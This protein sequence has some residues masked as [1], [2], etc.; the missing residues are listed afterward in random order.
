MPR[1]VRFPLF[2]A[3]K[4]ELQNILMIR[5]VYSTTGKRRKADGNGRREM[6]FMTQREI[7]RHEVEERLNETKRN[8]EL[9]ERD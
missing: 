7:E 2:D 6:D 5:C 4:F 8:R 1:S 3:V 9:E